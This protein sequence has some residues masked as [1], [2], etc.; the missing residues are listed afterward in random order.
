MS[1]LI[2]QFIMPSCVA[3]DK[4]TSIAHEGGSVLMMIVEVCKQHMLY[5]A[6]LYNIF[7]YRANFFRAKFAI[8]YNADTKNYY[9]TSL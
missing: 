8:D 4:E 5:A 6:L 9:M 3:D 2:T 1:S 7:V